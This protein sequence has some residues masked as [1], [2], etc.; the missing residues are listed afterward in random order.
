VG[1]TSSG[2]NTPTPLVGEPAAALSGAQASQAPSQLDLQ[3]LLTRAVAELAQ[4]TGAT[5][6][7]AWGLQPT[8]SVRILA[9]QFE[10]PT[11]TE[12]EFSDWQALGS[13]REATDLGAPEAP[14]MALRVALRHALHAAAPVGEAGAPHALLLLGSDREPPGAVRPRTLGRLA[15]V[16]RRLRG[17]L[18]AALAAERLVALDGEVRRLDRLAALGSLV[19]EIVH[20]IRNPLVSVKTFLQLLPERADDPD[21]HERFHRVASDELR[22][23]ERLLDGV[24][25]HARPSEGNGLVRSQASADPGEAI[26]SVRQ[27]VS[28]RAADRD[29]ALQLCP[30]GALP[31]VGL[32]EDGLRQVLLNLTLNAIDAT[33]PGGAVRLAAQA[34]A[35]C[36]VLCLEDDGPGVPEPL[37]ARLFEPFFTTKGDRP[38]GLGLAISQRIVEEAGGRIRALAGASGGARFEV[39][40]PRA[41]LPTHLPTRR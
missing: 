16:A 18:G 28:F 32:A 36:L 34:E 20:E 23:I 33:P 37:R 3:T 8:G 10:G 35:E 9:A 24:L 13:L 5:R 4:A 6:V 40:L 30:P 19:T 7:A 14:S 39:S 31:R 11:L 1:E 41:R 26:D 27:L 38:G 29:V 12:P 21:F 25:R 15:A 17:P 2:A 22:R